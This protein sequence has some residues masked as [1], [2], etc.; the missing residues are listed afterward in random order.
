LS[1][2]IFFILLLFTHCFHSLPSHCYCLLHVCLPLHISFTPFSPSLVIH[3]FITYLFVFIIFHIFHIILHY[4]HIGLPLPFSCLSY[5]FCYYCFHSFAF[6]F[7]IFFHSY[8]LSSFIFTPFLI[9]RLVTLI[10]HYY[11]IV[12][13]L[14]VIIIHAC[15]HVDA[16]IFAFRPILCYLFVI[17]SV[18]LFSSRH[19]SLFINITIFHS[20]HS[21]HF[22]CHCFSSL[23]LFHYY[24]SLHSSFFF[25]LHTYC[26][27]YAAS[28]LLVCPHYSLAAVIIIIIFLLY[29]SYAHISF[30]YSIFVN[31]WHIIV[32]EVSFRLHFLLIFIILPYHYY[33]YSSLVIIIIIRDMLFHYS[34][35]VIII[36]HAL[37]LLLFLLSFLHIHIVIH[38][39]FFHIHIT[40]LPHYSWI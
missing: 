16:H 33:S 25:R 23:L 21:S 13:R 34:P 39:F 9:F 22:H 37:P 8:S 24:V 29:L 40:Y 20:F 3:I 15:L 36:F 6:C 28:Y 5:L 7:S 26:H 31:I 11:I 27:Y 32:F 19:Y 38:Y 2:F 4:I 10:C 35:F 18:T 17:V 1:F 12:F 14:P 30:H